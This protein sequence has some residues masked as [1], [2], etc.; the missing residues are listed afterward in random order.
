[1]TLLSQSEIMAVQEE[2]SDLISAFGFTNIVKLQDIST[3]NLCFK[4]LVIGQRLAP[5]FNT[6]RK[7]LTNKLELCPLFCPRKRVCV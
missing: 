7:Q 3:Q 2:F 5:N 4:R 1:M 6:L